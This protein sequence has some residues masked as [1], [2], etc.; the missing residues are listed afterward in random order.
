MRSSG[1]ATQQVKS[2]RFVYHTTHSPTG[3]ERP[4]V[5]KQAL[6]VTWT[7]GRSSVLLF[8]SL[9]SEVKQQAE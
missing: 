1:M 2:H 8:F 6:C 5:K 4:Q 3:S 7:V 9:R